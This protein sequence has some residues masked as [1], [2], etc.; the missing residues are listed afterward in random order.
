[1]YAAVRYCSLASGP[2]AGSRQVPTY[3]AKTKGGQIQKLFFEM[4]ISTMTLYYATDCLSV[5]YQ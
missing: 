4:R 3:S 2:V 5:I 1:M